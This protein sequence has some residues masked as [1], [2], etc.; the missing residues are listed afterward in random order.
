MQAEDAEPKPRPR[1]AH[2]LAEVAGLMFR[3]GCTAFGGP[4]A[5][6][7]MLRQEVVERRRWVDEQEFLDLLGASGLIP[8]PTSTELVIH[9]GKTRAGLA[10]MW[11]AGLCFITPA[12]LI[13]LAIAWAYRAYGTLPQAGGLLGGVKPA[14]AVVI[15]GAL[16]GLGKTALKSVP[17][18]VL[19][20]GVMGLYLLGV[21][22]LGL[23]LA[24]GTAGMLLGRPWVR[25][26][27]LAPALLW[28]APAGAA[29]APP[30]EP[31]SI[32]LYFL[33][34]GSVLFGSG[35]VLLAFLREGL[36]REL[37]WLTD[38]QLMDAVAAG[39]FTPGPLFTTATFVGYLVG[40]WGGAAGATLGIFLPS[41]LMV[42]ATHG[43][44]RRL[45]E[46]A[47]SSGLLDG[48][49]AGSLGLMAGVLVQL[50]RG[51]LVTPAAWGIAAVAALLLFRLKWNSAWI[52]LAGGAAGLALRL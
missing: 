13:T 29:A 40:G 25:R 43:V 32:F 37:R 10:G 52:V 39:Q 14:V 12:A 49:N 27:P 7:A 44:V 8:G 48:V 42:W 46:A 38:Q 9:L 26:P 41:F 34:I 30:P 17:L 1:A 23:L 31:G 22:E 16:A 3:L 4:A 36:V 5:H 28:L 21:S 15:L 2:P 35:Y 19:A 24:S 45:R 50:G 47:W 51:A 18:T 33:K 6:I 11:L 20:A